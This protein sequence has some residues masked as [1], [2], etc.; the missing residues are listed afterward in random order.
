MK[1]SFVKIA[2]AFLFIAGAVV[3]SAETLL[4]RPGLVSTEWLAERIGDPGLRVIDARSSLKPYMQGHLPGAIYLNT[5]TARISEGGVPA[6]LLPAAEVAEIFGRLGI[7]NDHTV[8]IY[9]SA[10]E[11]FAHAAY[12]AYLLDWLGHESI[13]VLDGGFEKWQVEDR[14]ITREFP[15]HPVATFAPKVD[16]S[17]L[18][19]AA[20]V[21]RAAIEGAAVLLDARQPQQYQ[22][23][24]IPAARSFFLARTLEGDEVKAWKSPAELRQLAK[25]AGADGS[26]PI[27]TYCT[28]GREAAQIWFTLRHVAGFGEVASY[29]GSWIDWTS[30]GL[31]VGR[32]DPVGP[33]L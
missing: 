21:E 9:S 2:S 29:H 33:G 22:N 14:E 23:G 1:H 12:V 20:E 30:K 31:P 10:E 32:G 18:K 5:E 6:T 13:G 19:T 11:N 8:V 15:S 26:A 25:E 16:K 4:E 28:S 27:I 7:D 3:A 17:I 24:H